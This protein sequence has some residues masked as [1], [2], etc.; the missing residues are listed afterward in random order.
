MAGEAGFEPATSA[1]TMRRSPAELLATTSV[2]AIPHY[3][4]WLPGKQKTPPSWS[5]EA[6]STPGSRRCN[7]TKPARWRVDQ[8]VLKN[9]VGSST[10]RETVP[11]AI[12]H[13]HTLGRRRL[14]MARRDQHRR[15]GAE[16]IA[17]SRA[18]RVSNPVRDPRSIRAAGPEAMRDR[19]VREWTLV[20]QASD[21]SFP[22]S[23]PPS[24][25]PDPDEDA[26]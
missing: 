22:A 7:S 25:I 21:E 26:A 17:S 23:D 24:S 16:G 19:P 10:P 6:G 1:L 8:A 5:P 11:L 18:E 15:S 14:F 12:V 13:F 4:R 20:D 2:P 3:R 9:L